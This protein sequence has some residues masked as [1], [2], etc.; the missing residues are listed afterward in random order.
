M[1]Q[2]RVTLQSDVCTSS[3]VTWCGQTRAAVRQNDG[4]ADALSVADRRRDT[5]ATP[6]KILRIFLSFLEEGD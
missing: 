4:P 6:M 2:A 3:A 5:V 1:G